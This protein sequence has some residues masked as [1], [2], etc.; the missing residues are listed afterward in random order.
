MLRS[1]TVR[2]QPQPNSSGTL[3]KKA[4]KSKAAAA[5]TAAASGTPSVLS[6]SKVDMEVEAMGSHLRMTEKLQMVK[7]NCKN[8]KQ[9]LAE[10]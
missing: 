7:E 2:F 9:K 5:S 3:P 10:A 4:K 6:S 8:A 1:S